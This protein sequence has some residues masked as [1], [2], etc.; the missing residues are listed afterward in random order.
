MEPDKRRATSSVWFGIDY[1]RIW[2][3]DK[4]VTAACLESNGSL[5]YFYIDLQRAEVLRLSPL[6]SLISSLF[7]LEAA[8]EKL[9]IKVSQSYMS[10]VRRCYFFPNNLV[11]L[12]ISKMHD[13]FLNPAFV[14]TMKNQLISCRCKHIVF[15]FLI[16]LYALSTCG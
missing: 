9:H 4:W 5:V 10:E 15:R 2:I 1:R 12:C 7:S 3:S 14:H 11:V 13:C 8:S 16:H 6:L